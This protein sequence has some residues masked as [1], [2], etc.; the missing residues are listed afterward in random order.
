MSAES[1]LALVVSPAVAPEGELALSGPSAKVDPLRLPVRGDLAHIRLAGRVFVPHYAVPM[2]HRLK[3]AAP[4]RS[5]GRADADVL[6][7]LPAGEF[8]AVIDMAGGWAWGQA[9]D[10][11]G[12]V[13]YVALAA[14]EPTGEQD[15]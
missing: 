4:L 8:F 12:R 11:G 2:P 6:A 14:L 3:A 10:E 1:D 13:G 5:A 7:D 15:A 9:S